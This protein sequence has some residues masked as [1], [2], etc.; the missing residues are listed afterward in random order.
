MR[1]QLSLAL[2]NGSYLG[3]KPTGIGV[4][5][6]DLLRELDPVM[7]PL[8]DPLRGSRPGSIPIRNDLMPELGIRAHVRRL[9]WTQTKLPEIL[10]QAGSPILLSPLPE[11]PLLKGI[12]SVVIAHDLLPLRYPKINPLTLYHLGYVP[13]VLHSARKILCNSEAT[14]K[15]INRV[16]G[17]PARKLLT[18]PLGFDRENL[19]PLSLKRKPFFLV[20][21]RHNPHK[22]L[23]GVMKAF[24]QIKEKDMQI[25]FVGP[26][27][28]R[29]T[30]KLKKNPP[31]FF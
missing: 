13:F 14:A 18:I 26:H 9:I 27:D 2:F 30:P 25:W 10:R 28:P 1:P 15:E 19:K 6:R 24:S 3:P 4:V 23:F 16:L 29:Y 11:A 22:N 17:I 8:L 21:G 12:N 20:L 31:I 7:I 5:A